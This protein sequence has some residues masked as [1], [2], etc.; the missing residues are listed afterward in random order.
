MQGN[1]WLFNPDQGDPAVGHRRLEYGGQDGSRT[2]R[3]I[4]DR[5]RRKL[6]IRLN[7]AGTCPEHQGCVSADG[8]G[9]H[10]VDPRNC[11]V[12][13]RVDTAFEFWGNS[14]EG[15]DHVTKVL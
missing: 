6:D 9:V 3:A 2:D 8:I 15:T 13:V 7:V 10:A 12:Q 11:S 4:R 5:R 1:F 14:S